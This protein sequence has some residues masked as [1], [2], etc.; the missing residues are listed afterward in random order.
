MEPPKQQT[1]SIATSTPYELNFADGIDAK[2]E[3]KW[4]V[5]SS[6]SL[7]SKWHLIYFLIV[8]NLVLAA[9]GHLPSSTAQEGAELPSVPFKIMHRRA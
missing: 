6:I 1:A 4:K 2:V 3:R 8:E 7:T 5:I 9:T